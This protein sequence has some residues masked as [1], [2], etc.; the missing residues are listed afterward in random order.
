MN[1]RKIAKIVISLI[2]TNKFVLYV[3]MNTKAMQL[4]F[5]TPPCFIMQSTCN[6][7]YAPKNPR[8]KNMCILLAGL[9]HFMKLLLHLERY[10][11]KSYH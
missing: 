11:V 9:F 8:G 4:K 3:E 10:T 6:C 1:L 5:M 7:N 2:S